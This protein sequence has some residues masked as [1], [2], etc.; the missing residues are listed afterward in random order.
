MSISKSS[1][2]KLSLWFFVLSLSF[3]KHKQKQRNEKWKKMMI[4]MK[5][6]K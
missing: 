6:K 4:E 2:E 5:N 1:A 3:D